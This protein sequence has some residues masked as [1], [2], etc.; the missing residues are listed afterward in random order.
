MKLEKIAPTSQS[1]ENACFIQ[2]PVQQSTAQ[3]VQPHGIA[4]RFLAVLPYCIGFFIFR[5]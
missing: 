4:F 1:V 5:R 2:T 3:T